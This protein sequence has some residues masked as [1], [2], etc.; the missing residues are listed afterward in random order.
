MRAGDLSWRIT[1]ERATATFDEFNAP[2]EKWSPLAT[3]WASKTDVKDRERF[4]SGA[5]SS[6]LMTRF[7]IRW[8]SMVA[9]L[10]AKDRVN[11]SG[12]IYDIY[13]VKEIGSREGIEIT[14]AAKELLAGS[15]EIIAQA[16]ENLAKRAKPPAAID[17][18]SLVKGMKEDP[19]LVKK[20]E[21]AKA[22]K[23]EQ[24]S[25]KQAGMVA[26][27]AKPQAKP[28]ATQH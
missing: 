9:D 24:L 23:K 3:V 26:T 25:A 12:R 13:S 21:A 2:I 20:A 14:A 28:A 8:S 18:T 11:Y 10:N 17:L 22:K 27:R 5:V 6:D 7:R 1:I 19:E 15:P 16:E 4:A